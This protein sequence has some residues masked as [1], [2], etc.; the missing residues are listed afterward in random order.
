RRHTRSK[1]DWSSDVCSSDLGVISCSVLKEIVTAN[2][3]FLTFAAAFMILSVLVSCCVALKNTLVMLLPHTYKV[4]G[5]GISCPIGFHRS[6]ERRVGK[7]C[8][9]MWVMCE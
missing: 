1:R 2:P 8:R 9:T 3:T 5:T 4:G 6:E 7:E